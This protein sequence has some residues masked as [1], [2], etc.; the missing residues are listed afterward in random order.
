MAEAE[1]TVQQGTSLADAA[2]ALTDGNYNLETQGGLDLREPEQEQQA[3]AEEEAPEEE[4]EAQAAEADEGEGAA[5]AA[6]EQQAAQPMTPAKKWPKGKRV[7]EEVELTS[8]SQLA[9][10]LE[11][12]EDTLL[13]L[14][15][16]VDGEEIPLSRIKDARGASEENARVKTA[17]T[18][19]T[20][21]Q[22]ARLETLD[23]SAAVLA[24]TFTTLNKLAHQPGEHAGH[25]AVA[26]DRAGR[27]RPPA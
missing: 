2:R 25:G 27:T 14:T 22:Q 4:L 26:A 11:T 10:D 1:N 5:Q 24:Q 8:L 20:K 15:I 13:G 16:E 3:A 12:D 7:D 6:A 18:E 23:Q 17:L 9:A 19:A 21:Q